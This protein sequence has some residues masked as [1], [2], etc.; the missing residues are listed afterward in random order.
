MEYGAVTASGRGGEE[1]SADWWRCRTL[2]FAEPWGCLRQGATAEA[3]R[4]HRG[5]NTAGGA[6]VLSGADSLMARGSRP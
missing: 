1:W 4:E 5:V 6:G 3:G 2:A